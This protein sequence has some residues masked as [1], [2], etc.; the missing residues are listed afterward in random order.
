MRLDHLAGEFAQAF[1]QTD[2]V[3]YADTNL[4]C[5][6]RDAADAEQIGMMPVMG[7]GSRKQQSTPRRGIVAAWGQV[8][9]GNI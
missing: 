4:C 1:R 9:R 6:V 3:L 7:L 5:P 8:V 2:L